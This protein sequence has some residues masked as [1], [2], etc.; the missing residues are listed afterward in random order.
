PME[1]L[2]WDILYENDRLS[3]SELKEA[4]EGSPF[5][6]KPLEWIG[7]DACLMSSLEI[8]HAVSP[9]ARY[10]VASQETEP[11]KGWNYAF[12]KGIETAEN[13]AEAG[14]RIVDAYFE[15]LEGSADTLTL[16]C[17]DLSAL[18]KT[19]EAMNRFFT[20][21]AAKLDETSFTGFSAK[22]QGTKAVGSKSSGK[23]GTG[24]YDLVDLNDL[25]VNFE[26]QVPD[27][28]K[29]FKEA[30]DELVVY[31]RS[32]DELYSGLSLYYP[33]YSANAAQEKWKERYETVSFS[34]GY[35][36]YLGHF[37]SILTGEPVAGW[38]DLGAL[39][40]ESAGTGQFFYYQLTPEQMETFSSARLQIFGTHPENDKDPVY[41][42]IYETDEVT[43][44]KYGLLSA[45]YAGKAM[46]AVDEDGNVLN[47][48]ICYFESDGK[49]YLYGTFESEGTYYGSKNTE[50]KFVHVMFECKAAE[51]GKKVDILT[52]YVYDDVIQAYTNRLTID[53]EEFDYC[54]LLQRNRVPTYKDGIIQPFSEWEQAGVISGLY[55]YCTKP[56]KFVFLE[57]MGYGSEMYAWFQIRDVK[58][59]EHGTPLQEVENGSIKK[60]KVTGE[61]TEDAGILITPEAYQVNTEIKKEYR[62]VLE[63]QNVTE[64]EVEIADDDDTYLVNGT[65]SLQGYDISFPYIDG[66]GAKETVKKKLVI[67][68]SAL[69]GLGKLETLEFTVKVNEVPYQVKLEFEDVPLDGMTPGYTEDD[70]LARTEKDGVLFELLELKKTNI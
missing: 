53:P 20:E 48:P 9:Y 41:Y 12:L 32:T 61:V 57:N 65:R 47:G 68:A 50:D 5:R 14:R 3:L 21:L 30:L 11:G 55:V 52:I 33:Y 31:S 37:L 67:N 40:V 64:K 58:Q 69:E 10:M 43:M 56:W 15:A 46:Y 4:L 39:A 63:V 54:V 45:S 24:G 8:A 70:I 59:K 19:E 26:D 7:F 18:G 22:R 42:E 16:S 23:D 34:P 62:I 35:A 38:E 2:C 13:G 60:I 29:A 36:S 6:E 1:G 17:T 27:Q 51:D 49:I 66:L 25:V 28:A 44:D